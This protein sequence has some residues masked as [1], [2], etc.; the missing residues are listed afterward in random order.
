MDLYCTRPG[1]SRPHNRFADLDDPEVLKTVPQKFC[2]RCGMPLILD[3]RYLPIKLLGQGGFGAAFLAIDRRK[4]SHNECVVKQFQP[5][6]KL[7]QTQL[8]VAQKLFEREVRALDELG[9]AHPQIPDLFAFFDLAVAGM[10]SGQQ[11][12]FFYLVQEYIDGDTLEDELQRR[13]ALPASEVQTILE[14]VLKILQFVHDQGSIHRDIKPSNIMRRRDGL[15]FLLDFGAVKQATAH[16]PGQQS[17]GIYSQGFAPPEQVAGGTVY[18]CT[19][20]YALA[21]TCLM[22]LTGKQ[23]HELFDSYSNTW[24]WQ[25]YA[26][27]VPPTL[28]QALDRMV[29][30]APSERFQSAADVIAAL[31]PAA[32]P[33]LPRPTPTPQPS[34]AP[35]PSRSRA[36][37]TRLGLPPLSTLELLVS[38]G[39]IGFDVG[40]LAIA[41]VSLLGTTVWGGGFW[42]IVLGGLVLF[43]RRRVIDWK[44]LLIFGGGGLLLLLLIPRLRSI[45]VVPTLAQSMVMVVVAGVM[46]ALAA[47]AIATLFRL[48][49]KLLSL[50]L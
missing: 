36:S 13:G 43:Q 50:F 29:L 49:Y 24:K 20:L 46:T 37:V 23:H 10:Q 48:I 33:P 4:I 44:D 1:C 34:P 30:P 5:S 11:N 28:A 31:H 39:L 19:D 26:P 18:P 40:L 7:T 22:L 35:R 3:G 16:V 6:G 45:I 32:P 25:A 2:T 12:E 9:N 15:L 41:T 47:I 17:T 8:D 38:A 14:E 27:Q 21:V 42:L